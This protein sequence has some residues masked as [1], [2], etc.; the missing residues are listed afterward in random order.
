MDAIEEEAY[1]CLRQVHYDDYR[2]G[3]IPETKLCL[4]LYCHIL[5]TVT[6]CNSPLCVYRERLVIVYWHQDPA[7]FGCFDH[8]LKA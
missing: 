8:T 7:E 6:S 5:A 2:C 3:V 1:H 4:D